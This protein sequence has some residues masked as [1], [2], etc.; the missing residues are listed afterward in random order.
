MSV[1]LALKSAASSAILRVKASASVARSKAFLKRAV[2]IS[3][4]VRV[5]L[6]MLRIALRRLTIARVLAMVGYLFSVFLCGVRSRGIVFPGE[7]SANDTGRIG[8]GGNCC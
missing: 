3:S 1:A 4:M 7:L 6:R 5:I 2:A 8:E